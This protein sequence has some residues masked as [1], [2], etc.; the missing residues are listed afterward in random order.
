MI[1]LYLL[2]CQLIY[3]GN[4]DKRKSSTPSVE[5][6]HLFSKPDTVLGVNKPFGPLSDA[7]EAKHRFPGFPFEFPPIIPGSSKKYLI[8]PDDSAANFMSSARRCSGLGGRMLRL[9][10]PVEMEILACAI[11][12]PVFFASWMGDDFGG[13][14]KGACPVLY[15]GGV[16][17]STIIFCIPHHLNALD[18]PEGCSSIFGSICEVPVDVKYDAVQL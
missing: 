16:I 1:V 2:V 13:P 4:A 3:A 14:L 12:G 9:E 15:P 7:Y 5:H 10:T 6:S 17:S 8:F 18:S 11:Q